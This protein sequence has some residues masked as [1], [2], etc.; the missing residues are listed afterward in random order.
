MAYDRKN[1]S[2]TMISSSY[3]RRCGVQL[4]SNVQAV[5]NHKISFLLQYKTKKNNMKKNKHIYMDVMYVLATEAAAEERNSLLCQ[6]GKFETIPTRFLAVDNLAWTNVIRSSDETNFICNG[7]LVH[8][9][10]VFSMVHDSRHKLDNEVLYILKWVMNMNRN[11]KC[12][13]DLYVNADLYFWLNCIKQS[14]IISWKIQY[15][16]LEDHVDL[17][18]IYN[19]FKRFNNWVECIEINEI[20]ID[21]PIRHYRETW[22]SPIKEIKKKLDK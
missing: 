15:P 20:E 9:A 22:R 1:H 10:Y 21:P 5:K 18:F 19:I 13:M 17:L 8:M 16:D 12:F 6:T 14:L 3:N 2:E 4:R 11:L 7:A